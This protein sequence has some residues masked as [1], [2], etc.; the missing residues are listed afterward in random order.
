MV[1]ITLSSWAVSLLAF[2]Y[3]EAVVLHPRSCSFSWPAESGDTC[4]SMAQAWG[5]TESQFISFN[6]GVI[7][8]SLIP[9]QDY[10]VEW[11]GS[12]PPM[13]STTRTSVPPVTTTTTPTGPSPT[14]EGIA[15]DCEKYYL[16]KSGDTCQKI[17]DTYKTFTLNQF[18]SWNPAVGKD[19]SSLWVD[20]Y[21][22]VAVKGTPDQPPPTTTPPPSDPNKP[23]PAQPNV[24]PKCNKW[25][26]VSSGDTCQKISDAY[27]ISLSTFYQWNPD[28]GSSCASLWLGYYVC[29]GSQ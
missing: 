22:C 5:I 25:Y 2:T 18:Y 16:V 7:C 28:V 19:C 29:V 4:L 12:P 3:V 14:Q 10:C 13:P 20:Y 26:L 23:S 15:K 8:A 11:D 9:G 1:T 6:P 21:V 24:N 27:K 17:A